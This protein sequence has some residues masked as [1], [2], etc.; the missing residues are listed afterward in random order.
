[1]AYTCEHRRLRSNDQKSSQLIL[2]ILEG[3]TIVLHHEDELPFE[4]VEKFVLPVLSSLKEVFNI[5]YE[6]D[7]LGLL[8]AL[9]KQHK[10]L[11]PELCLILSALPGLYNKNGN[12]LSILRPIYEALSLDKG[13]AEEIGYEYPDTIRLLL[14]L[15]T[16]Y[17]T[18]SFCLQ[19]YEF[20][21]LET[22]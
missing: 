8:E 9:L 13:M 6:E 21:S 14:A 4:A 12:K 10:H 2:K 5:E 19:E 20:Y 1:M 22:R 17:L 18:D 15:A 11:T 7:L 16:D 3:L